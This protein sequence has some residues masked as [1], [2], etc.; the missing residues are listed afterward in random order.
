MPEKSSLWESDGGEVEKNVAS[1]A[2]REIQRG[3][4]AMRNRVDMKEKETR[5]EVEASES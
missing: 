3:V 1:R 5:K 4:E 2:H